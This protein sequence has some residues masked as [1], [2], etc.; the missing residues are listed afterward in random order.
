LIAHR[1]IKAVL[2]PRYRNQ[3]MEIEEIASAATHLSACEQRSVKAERAV[4]S[5]KKARFIRRYL[6][7]TLEGTVTSVAKFGIF[8]T[9]REFEIDGL[10]KLESLGPDRWVFDDQNM[11]LYGRRTGRVFKLGDP[12]QVVV[13][14]VDIGAGKIDFMLEDEGAQVE[15]ALVVMGDDMDVEELAAAAEELVG[16]SSK[17]GRQQ[18][19]AQES[20]SK[21]AKSKDPRARDA[22][23]EKRGKKGGRGRAA[24]GQRR[25]AEASAMA[26]A[27]AG[28]SSTRALQPSGAPS[29][30][31]PAKAGP[32]NAN[33]KQ[34]AKPGKKPKSIG[35]RGRK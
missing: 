17:R 13:A 4:I 26:P 23:A 34:V 16:G 8:V 1:L 3:G 10:V 20:R 9:L 31:V 12:L 6:G 27:K 30:I 5:I 25:H 29:K 33:Q 18:A 15:E 24:K 19:R 22:Q 32:K 21:D 11:R 28:P 2:Y 14:N 7:Q 35:R